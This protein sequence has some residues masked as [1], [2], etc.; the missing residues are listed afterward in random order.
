M[1]RRPVR[2]SHVSSIGWEDGTMEVEF[3]SGHIWQYHEVP[4][5]EYRNL[6]GASSVGKQM[7]GIKDRFEST[8]VK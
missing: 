6:M 5:G 7:A 3:V 4:E 1:N 2:S 8:K